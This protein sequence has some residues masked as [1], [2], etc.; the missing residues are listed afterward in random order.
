MNHPIT[1]YFELEELICPHV[2][3]NYGEAAWKFIDNRLLDVLYIIR[4]GI[5]KPIFVNDW[6][7]GGTLSQRGLR[8]NICS[9]VKTK[10]DLEKVYMT[11][12]GQGEAVDFHVKD[13]T[14]NEVRTWICKNQVLLPHNIRIEVDFDVRG[15]SEMQVL[16][17]MNQ[18]K[19]TWVHIDLRGEDQRI[20]FF[21]G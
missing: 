4:K 6:A 1:E 2:S 7:N 21:K 14:A 17:Q 13:M 3:A 10:T 19:M 5:D 18:C 16:S 9:L 20:T 8:C 12:H 11:A 15:K